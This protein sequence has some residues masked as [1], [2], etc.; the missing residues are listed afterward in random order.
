MGNDSNELP[1]VPGVKHDVF[2]SYARNDNQPF[3]NSGPGWVSLFIDYLNSNL[4][5]L[6][7]DKPAIWFDDRNLNKAEDFDNSIRQAISSSALF[8]ALVSPGYLKSPYCDMELNW[9]KEGYPEG[10]FFE[11]GSRVIQVRTLKPVSWREHD[12]IV[13][14]ALGF[15]FHDGLQQ[16]HPRDHRFVAEANNLV[17]ALYNMLVFLRDQRPSIVMPPPRNFQLGSPEWEHYNELKQQLHADSYR[18][19][20]DFTWIGLEK[21]I[22][23]AASCVFFFSET[24]DE[25]LKSLLVKSVDLRKPVTVGLASATGPS[26]DFVHKLKN[27]ARAKNFSFLPTRELSS[28]SALSDAVAEKLALFHQTLGAQGDPISA[29]PATSQALKLI[30]IICDKIDAV[31]EKWTDRIKLHEEF[32]VL[33]PVAIEDSGKNHKAGALKEA[34]AQRLQKS[35]SAVLI[36]G[37]KTEKEWFN[38]QFKTMKDASVKSDHKA[39]HLPPPIDE[40][41]RD[42]K[43]IANGKKFVVIEDEKEIDTFLST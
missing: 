26:A 29:K 33:W 35:H 38:Q 15:V 22:P 40:T 14:K 31:V 37:S 10:L 34:H 11:K 2:I 23:T 32:E 9:M 17:Q 8:V 30:Y 27:R 25:G 1:Y 13:P 6:L 12:S 19:L 20:G 41:K 42:A 18:V 4:S 7:G 39:I 28:Y 3:E 21:A 43:V 5:R 24:L 36:W 16:F